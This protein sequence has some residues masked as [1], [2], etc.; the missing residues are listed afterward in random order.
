LRASG[1]SLVFFLVPFVKQ[2]ARP[3]PLIRYE[4]KNI[5][6]YKL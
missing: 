3:D 2:K 6:S 5:G 4:E 1:S